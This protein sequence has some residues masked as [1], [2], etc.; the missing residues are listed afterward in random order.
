VKITGKS[1]AAHFRHRSTIPAPSEPQGLAKFY[2]KESGDP[3][4]CDKINTAVHLLG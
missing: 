2:L 4:A 3:T 1:Y